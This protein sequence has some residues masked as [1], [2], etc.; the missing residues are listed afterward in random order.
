MLTRGKHIKLILKREQGSAIVAAPIIILIVIYLTC[1]FIDLADAFI[2]ASDVNQAIA[3]AAASSTT[4]ISKSKFYNY[5]QIAINNGLAYSQAATE[6]QSALPS[7][8]RLDTPIRL[9]TNGDTDCIR[10]S[11]NITLPLPLLPEYSR[12]IAYS[13]S[14]SAI[15]K[16]AG[17]SIPPTC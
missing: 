14:S 1:F 5:G 12:T 2:K 6:I 10:A 16:G 15:A 3:L 11:V 8:V 4:E 7:Q 9:V 13:D 17:I